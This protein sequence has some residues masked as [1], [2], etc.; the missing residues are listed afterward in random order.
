MSKLLI[1]VLLLNLLLV[2]VILVGGSE[3]PLLYSLPSVVDV[4]DL[5]LIVE[6]A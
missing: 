2:V 1:V 4:K 5:L 3:V 6:V